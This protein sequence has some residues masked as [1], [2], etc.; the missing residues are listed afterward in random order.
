MF[1]VVRRARG[2]SYERVQR[3]FRERFNRDHPHRNTIHYNYMK[4]LEW[5]TSYNRCEYNSGRRRTARVNANIEA[6][7]NAIEGV[8]RLPISARRNGLGIP[9]SSFNRI[10]LR[11]LNFHPYRIRIR[12]ALQE[13]DFHRRLQFCYWF[14]EQC[15]DPDFIR[16]VVIGDEAAF[17]MNGEVNTKNVVRYAPKGE[18]PAFNYDRSNS[19]E[20]INV[21]VGLCGDGTIIGPYY[22][23]GN[24]NGNEYLQM[25]NALVIPELALNYLLEFNRLWW[26]Q[27]GA[28]PHRHGDVLE[29][30]VE[31]FHNRFVALNHAIEWPARSP[32]LTPC[33]FFFWG[34]LKSQVFTSPPPS[35]EALRLRITENVDLLR[36]KPEF[37]LNSFRSM[38]RRANICIERGGRHVE[39]Q[40]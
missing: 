28:G 19:R 30:L 13:G 18:P 24:V 6:V 14:L 17:S 7:R 36:A 27:D 26:F 29:R 10:T 20:K 16:L 25:L 12:H 5:G 31:I 21:W 34:Y 22:F 3:D 4:Y 1:V 11:E 23:D 39:G 9:K 15:R 32:D 37:I 38:Q 40:V 8:H 33:D 35:I 2:R